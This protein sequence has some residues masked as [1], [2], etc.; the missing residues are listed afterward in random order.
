LDP[1]GPSVV[2]LSIDIL[3]FAIAAISLYFVTQQKPSQYPYVKSL[4]ILV[5]IFFEGVVVL[6]TLRNVITTPSFTDLYTVGAT[7]FILWDV[8]LLT[9]I[10]YSVYVR[11]GGRGILGRL[12]S[13]FLRW[14]HGFILAT[15]LVYMGASEAYLGTQHPWSIVS[16]TTLDG[17]TLSSTSF[18][19][20]F[21]YDSLLTLVFFLAYPTLLLIR[22]T[23]QVRDPDVKRALVILPFCW[24]GIGAELLFFN[25]YLVAIGFDL[26][27][28]GY[29]IAALAFGIAATIFRRASLISSFFQP[30][31]GISPAVLP[32]A[33]REGPVLA[34][35]LP[36]LLVVDPAAN[37]EA[38]VRDFAAE[39]VSR[40]GLVYV[41]TSKGSPIYNS[42]SALAGARF[43]I[44]TSQVSY[45]KTS[46]KENELLVPQ[47]DPAVLLDLLDKTIASTADTP[48]S[49][50][51]DSIS[52]FILYLG[53][54]SSYKFV[55]QANEILDR[56]KVSSLYLIT[57]GAHEERVM[58]LTKSLFRMHLTYDAAGLKVTRATSAESTSK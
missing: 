53:F 7:S 35:A 47:N 28:V 54:E 26:I 12:K 58:S 18:N 19:P 30:I 10:A 50:V 40:G 17:V 39:K 24:V 56:P 38:A 41:F 9:I 20:T 49:F 45:P 52:D 46:D 42:L 31:P 33:R 55:K 57:T 13:I 6:E 15:F 51:I 8:V 16:L 22:E 48:V 21:L 37:Y 11:P 1:S 5:H 34:A 44:L 4:L 29:V 3:T 2:N 36:A 32:A 27:A 43:F 25:G 14:P 23:L